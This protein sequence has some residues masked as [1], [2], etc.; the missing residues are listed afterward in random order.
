MKHFCQFI[1]ETS[2]LLGVFVVGYPSKRHSLTDNRGTLSFYSLTWFRLECLHL[3]L[4]TAVQCQR[5]FHHLLPQTHHSLL[6]SSVL[7]MF[8]PLFILFWGIIE[9]ISS[10]TVFGDGFAII[11]VRKLVIDSPTRPNILS[12][13]R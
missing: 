6:R 2:V 5:H 9:L 1:E 3:M 4:S 12:L 10:L 11:S 8:F 13:A 7:A